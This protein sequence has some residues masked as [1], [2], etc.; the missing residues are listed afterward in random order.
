MTRQSFYKLPLKVESDICSDA[1]QASNSS[2]SP[3]PAASKLAAAIR[4]LAGGSHHVISALFGLE[5]ANFF[6]RPTL[7]YAGSS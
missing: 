2:G 4:Y 5:Q 6:E 3:I 7:V 1:T